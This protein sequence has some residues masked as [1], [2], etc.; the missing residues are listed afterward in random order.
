MTMATIIKKTERARG[1]GYRKKGGMYLVS[2]GIAAGCCLL[3]QELNVCPCCGAGIKQS[4]GFTWVSSELLTNPRKCGDNM[5]PLL[6]AMM[7]S[8][9]MGLMWVGEKYYN[10][11]A[12]FTR[13]GM[14]MG[15]SKRIAQIPNDLIVGETWV[16]LAHPKAIPLFN[17]DTAGAKTNTGFA[18]GIFQAFKPSHIEY[19]VT[20]NE[21]EEELNRME[22]R[23]ITLIDVTRDVDMQTEML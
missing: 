2:D 9:R 12:D 23:G 16:L 11:A 17:R 18:P 15:V 19:I 20:G 21:T 14:A 4:R 1:C 3:P 10:T 13:E 8:E 7:T 5:C 6:L 22:K